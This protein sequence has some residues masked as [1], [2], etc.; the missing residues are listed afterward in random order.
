MTV[1]KNKVIFLEKESNT[2]E[3]LNSREKE[4]I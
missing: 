2:N 3:K 4:K 1:S